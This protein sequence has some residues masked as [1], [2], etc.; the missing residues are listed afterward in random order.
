MK[1]C[2]GITPS[3]FCCGV[4]TTA[5][6]GTFDG[7]HRGHRCI[8]EKVVEN[9]RNNGEQSAVVTFDRH[10]A[11]VL[12]PER[13]PGILTTADEKLSLFDEIGIDYVFVITFSPEVADM[14]P[15]TFIAEYLVGCLGMSHFI[16]G[17]DHGFGKNRQGSAKILETLSGVY[18]FTVEIQDP[19]S[20]DG[21]V[22]N[23]STIRRLILKGHVDKAGAM[24]ARDYALEGTVVTGHGLGK[25][26]GIPTT[27]VLP[28]HPEKILPMNGVYT[29]WIA[30][31]ESKREAVISIGPRLTFD[32]TEVSI[33]AHIPDYSGDLYGETIRIGFSRRL[34]NIV[35]FDSAESLVEQIKKDIDAMNQLITL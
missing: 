22:V 31:E 8:L 2:T 13:V 19:V 23:S 15:E 21:I 29:G 20:L 24:L 34:R 17:Y 18:G 11:S 14:R 7:I 26:I 5:T 3:G 32:G 6:L 16:V 25:K 27:N 1:V 30:T 4:K 10:P 12:F 28:T 35:K 9:A 33:E